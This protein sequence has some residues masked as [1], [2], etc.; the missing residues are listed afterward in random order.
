MLFSRQISYLFEFKRAVLAFVSGQI[1]GEYNSLSDWINK[2]HIK[3]DSFLD[4]VNK[5]WIQFGAT[6]GTGSG[7]PLG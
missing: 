2:D 5:Y 7:R 3:L 1:Y 4:T 6:L